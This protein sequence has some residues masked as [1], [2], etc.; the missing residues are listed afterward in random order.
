MGCCLYSTKKFNNIK[1]KEMERT[2]A[3]DKYVK[4]QLKK[5]KEV[6]NGDIIITQICL[7]III[8]LRHV[9]SNNVTF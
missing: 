6:T 5:Y 7:K 9:I 2:W 8:E 3:P 1:V 4:T